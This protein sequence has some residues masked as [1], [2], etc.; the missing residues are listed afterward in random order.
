MMRSNDSTGGTSRCHVYRV[1]TRSD[2]L[3]L[4]RFAPALIR[5]ARAQ[6]KVLTIGMSFPLTGTL[7]LQAG[8]A[9][10]AVVYA[11]DEAN[12]KGGVA[13]YKLRDAHAG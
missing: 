12:E 4:P 9:R 1:A 6:E 3:A 8:Q 2:C 7:A 11:I 13:G 10:D 5:A